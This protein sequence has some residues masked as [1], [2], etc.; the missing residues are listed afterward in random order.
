MPFGESTYADAFLNGGIPAL[1]DG[2]DGATLH[3]QIIAD[4]DEAYELTSEGGY[5]AIAMPTLPAASGGFINHV[6]DFGTATGEWP[7]SAVAWVW[8]DAVG[9]V[10]YWDV[11]KRP[12]NVAE[13][14]AEAEAPLDIYVSDPRRD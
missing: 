10:V 9:D 3:L 11:L 8:R 6:A 14:G 1:P 4:T 5:E 12:L 7:D 2:S 13:A